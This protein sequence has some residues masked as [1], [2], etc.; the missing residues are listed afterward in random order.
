MLWRHPARPSRSQNSGTKPGV[1]SIEGLLFAKS[2]S[3]FWQVLH[4]RSIF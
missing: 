4:R 2:C 3:S 1:S